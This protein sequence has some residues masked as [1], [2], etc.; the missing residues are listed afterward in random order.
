MGEEKTL[1]RF[2]D[3]DHMFYMDDLP[4]VNR[5][6]VDVSRRMFALLPRH[7]Q[8]EGVL[9]GMSD[10]CFRDNAFVFLTVA[11]FGVASP[12]FYDRGLHKER[13]GEDER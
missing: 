13:S 10:T 8:A 7:I 2:I 12:V 11:I 6:N 9:H 3:E 4:I 1:I 5:N